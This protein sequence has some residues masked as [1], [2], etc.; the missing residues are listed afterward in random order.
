MI[1]ISLFLSLSRLLSLAVSHCLSV[2]VPNSR[3]MPPEQFWGKC[4]KRLLLQCRLS[5]RHHWHVIRAVL[6]WLV[7][8]RA[9]P[10]QFPGSDRAAGLRVQCRVSGRA[11]P[12]HHFPLLCQHLRG[13]GLPSV[14]Q[15]QQRAGGVWLLAGLQR[16]H[17]RHLQHPLLFRQVYR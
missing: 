3:H 8:G 2:C 12:H 4:A 6:Q 15:R 5:G 14:Q 1:L 11:Y 13:R 10:G 9:V 7:R 16:G 17:Q